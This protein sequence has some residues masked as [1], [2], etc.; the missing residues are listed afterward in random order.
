MTTPPPAFCS[1][2]HIGDGIQNSISCGSPSSKH[3]AEK[4][5]ASINFGRSA[6]RSEVDES[7]CGL[8]TAVRKSKALL[9]QGPVGP[10]FT[11]LQS[12]LTLSGWSTR[13]VIFNAG[14]QIFSSKKDCVRFTGDV[15]RWESWLQFEISQNKPDCIILFGS[16]RPAHKVA[17]RI[18]ELFGIYVLSLEE[19]YLRSGYV[20]VEQGGNN[21]HS[22]LVE[23]KSHSSK[24]PHVSVGRKVKPA[25]SSFVMMSVWGATYYLIRDL[26]SYP[27]DEDLFHRPREG[28]LH[29]SW[30]W[31]THM[32][33]RATSWITEV[34]PRRA[35]HRNPGFIIV[36]LQVS[37]D[38]QIQN[39]ARGWTTGKLV[40]QCL[41]ALSKINPRQ[42][43]VF[44]LHPLERS[45][46]KIK[47][48]I[49]HRA[50][51]LGVDQTRYKILHTGRIGDLTAHSSG[52]VVINSTSAFSALHHGVPLLVLGDAIYRH[53]AIATI[54]TNQNDIVGFFTLRRSKSPEKVAAFFDAV[55]SQSLLPGDFYL[56]AGRKEA[57]RN[58]VQKLNDIPVAPSVAQEAVT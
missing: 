5:N 52:M 13:R 40:D 12:A 39:G 7:T 24:D 58:I 41:T 2:N 26:L 51:A 16:S 18:A 53:D 45:S 11:D 29:L 20:S 27:S 30:R 55:K 31:C 23:W 17:R 14:D 4:M 35:L 44:K 47:R 15:D 56:S 48:M 32:L 6:N 38:S 34:P 54:G 21:Q 36:P 57:I 3:S 50:R 22:P 1:P 28:V 8:R 10:F 46:N 49:V 19:G 25:K 33:R 42:T 9:L 37:N 43:V